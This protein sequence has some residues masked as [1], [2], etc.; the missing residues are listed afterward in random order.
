MERGRGRTLIASRIG[1]LGRQRMAALAQDRCR[2]RVGA[3]GRNAGAE[4]RRTIGVVDRD[5]AAGLCRAGDR[6]CGV[7]REAVVGNRSRYRG[8]VVRDRADH[9]RGRRRRVLGHNERTGRITL[10]TGPVGDPRRKRIGRAVAQRPGLHVGKT[11]GDIAGRQRIGRTE[12]AA[13]SVAV[14]KLDGIAGDR[15]G[16]AQTHSHREIGV[17]GRTTVAY[18]TRHRR[19]VIGH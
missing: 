15:I 5:R 9:G 10:V 8:Y 17:I 6:Q 2:D 4:H 13:R 3:T 11:V 14:V 1:R 7:V 19:D 12:L 18:R 16:A